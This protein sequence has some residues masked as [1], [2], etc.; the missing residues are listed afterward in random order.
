M[1]H[2]AIARKWRPRTFDE[3]AGQRHVTHTL[4]NAIRLGR[5]HHAFLMTGA[6]GVGK[7]SAARILARAVNCE[8]GPAENPCNE[9]T[10][11]QEMLAGTFPDLIEIDAASHNSVD[12]IRDLVEKVQYAPQRARYKIYIIDEVHMVTKQGFN[13]LLKTLEE[14]PPHVLFILA[15]TDPQQLLDTVI[16]R[17][18]R[19]DFKMI[20]VRTIYE[21]LKFVAEQEGV[22]VPDASLKVISREGGG[23]MRDAQSLLDQVLSF[24]G[25]SVTEDEVAEILGFIDRSL[26]YDV[27]ECSLSGNA[28][29]AIE[30][31]SK[32]AQFGYDVRTFTNQLLEAVRNVSL[33]AH[34]QE[35]DRLLDLPDDEIEGLKRL[36]E[37]C[38]RTLVHQQFDILADAL[39][40][41][42]R[43]EQPFLLLE[44]AVV[45]MASCCPVVAVGGLVERLEALE[46][47]IRS[48]SSGGNG[49][50]SRAD[51]RAPG[52]R[53]RPDAPPTEVLRSP[54][55]RREPPA[56]PSAPPEQRAAEPAPEPVSSASPPPPPF[57][58]EVLE[59]AS[60]APP[61]PPPFE[62]E[63]LEPASATP[64][65]SPPPPIEEPVLAPVP[66]SAPTPP[67]QTGSSALAAIQSYRRKASPGEAASG[68]ALPGNAS[69]E[70]SSPGGS[71]DSEEARGSGTAPAPTAPGPASSPT[72]EAET[73]K[74]PEAAVAPRAVPT[75]RSDPPG[76][77]LC[78]APKWRQFVHD[79][80][81]EGPSS[82][83]Y[84][85]FALS[86]F[87]G[88]DQQCIRVAFR[89]EMTLRQAR[90]MEGHVEWVRALDQS[91]GAGTT[92][93][94]ELDREGRSGKSLSETLDQMKADALAGQ[95][96]TARRHPRVAA[97]QERFPGS[98]IISVRVPPPQEIEHVH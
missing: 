6:R 98:E 68:G 95:E 75:D 72:E 41:I 2:Q 46:S 23:S 30:E 52:P 32:V 31:L 13:A 1:S 16:S 34:I 36:A 61:P 84:A 91:F 53:R 88:C 4:Q 82:I 33:V 19:F 77:P 22:Q 10:S 63:V 38:D 87:A 15:T 21:R 81:R 65:P 74:A 49:R 86:G 76:S 47:R 97:T 66:A 60:A 12:A 92:V 20:P 43:S 27:L 7:T 78:D 59:P 93:Q 70:A 57:E 64:L 9:C 80:S 3:I 40:R 45:K 62:D 58:D 39:D 73:A 5:I 50:P 71:V 79:L 44:M 96:D 35:P 89:T 54:S 29:G 14:P 42:A 94:L 55:Q 85:I 11:C 56:A 8:T 26:L 25:D 90:D 69:T 18:Q 83:L 67:Q 24:S 51:S 17:C 37:Y 28:A 48:G